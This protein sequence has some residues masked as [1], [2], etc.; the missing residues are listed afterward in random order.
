VYCASLTHEI[1]FIANKARALSFLCYKCLHK[2][3]EVC[4]VC[5]WFWDWDLVFV[6]RYQPIKKEREGVWED[7]L[8]Q[9][10]ELSTGP[11]C[12]H[13]PLVFHSLPRSQARSQSP[14]FLVVSFS[15][16]LFYPFNSRFNFD[17]PTYIIIIIV[18][19]IMIT[20]IIVIMI[21]VVIIIIPFGDLRFGL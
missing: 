7:E 19:I 6:L 13:L 5:C 3:C 17:F 21:T 10:V 8:A 11:G 20:V 9:G 18:I 15:P 4:F 16:L 12:A 14:L 1:P 2:F